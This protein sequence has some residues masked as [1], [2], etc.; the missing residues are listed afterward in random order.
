MDEGRNSKAS[1]PPPYEVYVPRG[2]PNRDLLKGL[3]SATIRPLGGDLGPV[4]GRS[5]A[6]HPDRP[7]REKS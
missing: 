7:D 6:I 5:R 4:L 1:F 2:V 3:G